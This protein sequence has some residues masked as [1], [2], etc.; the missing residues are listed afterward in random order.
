LRFV[1]CAE[2]GH[3]AL[4]FKEANLVERR[5]FLKNAIYTSATIANAG[6]IPLPG[7]TQSKRIL[8]RGGTFFLGPAFVEAALADGHTV[9]FFNRGVTNPERFHTSRS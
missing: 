4:T 6:T 9:T 1:H 3:L 8:V 2:G 5:S 7:E